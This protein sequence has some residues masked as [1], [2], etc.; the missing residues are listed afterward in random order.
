MTSVVDKTRKAR[1]IWFE[2]VKR[3]CTDAL[4]RKCDRLTDRFER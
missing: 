4:V 3:R 2:H 1:P